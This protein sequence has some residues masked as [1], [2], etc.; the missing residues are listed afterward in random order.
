MSRNRVGMDW[1]LRWRQTRRCDES[2]ITRTWTYSPAVRCVGVRSPRSQHLT[3]WLSGVSWVLGMTSNLRG[4]LKASSTSLRCL[5]KNCRWRGRTERRSGAKRGQPDK[6]VFARRR[7][8]YFFHPDCSCFSSLIHCCGFRQHKHFRRWRQFM[9]LPF[10]SKVRP[11][12]LN[13]FFFFL[14]Q[15]LIVLRKW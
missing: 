12:L 13:F 1:K 10:F 2:R 7:P 14:H 15:N 6:H 5:K 11:F 3:A 8:T 9:R 4:C